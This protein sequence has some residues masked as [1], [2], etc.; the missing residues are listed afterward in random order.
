[1]TLTSIARRTLRLVALAGLLG[2]AHTAAAQTPCGATVCTASQFCVREHCYARLATSTP[3]TAGPS[4]ALSPPEAPGGSAIHVTVRQA[5]TAPGTWV[6]LTSAQEGPSA[7]LARRDSAGPDAT[8]TFTA[9]RAAGLY[10]IVLV[11]GDS[12]EIAA[13][14]DLVVGPLLRPREASAPVGGPMHV[15]VTH[16]T[17]H[18]S[19][20]VGL[21][22]STAPDT[23]FVTMQ[24][25]NGASSPPPTGLPDATLTF[26][27]PNKSADYNFRFFSADTSLPATTS[28]NVRV[29]TQIVPSRTTVAPDEPVTAAVFQPPTTPDDFAALFG[30]TAPDTL[31]TQLQPLATAPRA[32]GDPNSPAIIQI[33]APSVQAEVNLRAFSGASP[34]KVATSS[35]V[36]VTHASSPTDSPYGVVGS[37]SLGNETCQQTR[38]DDLGVRWVRIS[39]GWHE[40]EPQYRAYD[41]ALVERLFAYLYSR[42][43][44]V[45]WDFSY[46]P[47][48]A[49]GRPCPTDGDDRKFPPTPDHL[50]DMRQY[51]QGVVSR[52]AFYQGRRAPV[53]WGTWNEID[54]NFYRLPDQAKNGTQQVQ[55][56]SQQ[57]LPTVLSAIRA[58]DPGATIAVGEMERV[59]DTHTRDH[60]LLRT[61]LQAADSHGGFSLV[62]HHVYGWDN[63]VSGRLDGVRLLLTLLSD[64][65]YGNKDLWVT[66]VGIGNKARPGQDHFLV[67]F[68]DGMQA[69]W[70]R[71]WTKTFW[72]NFLPTGDVHDDAGLLGGVVPC[73]LWETSTYWTYHDYILGGAHA[74]TPLAP[75]GTI[76]TARPEYV[77]QVANRAD[78]YNLEVWGANGVIDTQYHAMAVCSGAVCEATPAI[79]LPNGAY[80]WAVQG[81]WAAGTAGPW[82]APLDFEVNVVG[83]C[84]DDCTY[85]TANGL[86]GNHT[87]DTVE[88]AIRL[89]EPFDPQHDV[90]TTCSA[91]CGVRGDHVCTPG[92][93]EN[94]LTSPT[95]CLCAAPLHCEQVPGAR[96]GTGA[97]VLQQSATNCGGQVCAVGQTCVDAQCL[98]IPPGCGDAI[99]TSD[100]DCGTC[101]DDCGCAPG[102]QCVGRQCG[103]ACGD[104]ICAPDVEGCGNCLQDCPCQEGEACVVDHCEANLCGDGVCAPDIEGCGNCLQD[105]PCP[106][107]EACVVDHCEANLCGDGICAPDVE[108]CGNCL[109]D[110]P[111]QEGEACVVDHCE[112]NLCGDGVCAPDI[113]G[114]GNCLQDCPCQEGEACV[115]DHC[116]ATLCGDGVCA[117]DIEGCGNCLQD[118]PCPEGEACAV[119]HCEAL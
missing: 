5:P 94:C 38:L 102:S 89:S 61:L 2:D 65:G 45:Y 63:T 72:Y 113:E 101:P 20:R 110:C 86:C 3:V 118:C 18:S 66:E 68:L 23:R 40:I 14:A 21:F 59:P 29:G 58:A 6:G 85:Y 87:C 80:R 74:P 67:G 114:C 46:A 100:E 7:P 48:W 76:D 44:G 82:S 26:V 93:F 17:G 107:G 60:P 109:Q 52:G 11:S 105:C 47:C 119:D 36:S 13:S 98:P 10:R 31:Y 55:H 92:A 50:E 62:S 41:W 104:G 53:V 90:S 73:D 95:D 71:R 78:R 30:S 111:C 112:A 115:V 34:V 43:Y 70:A 22:E 96:A 42:G 27:A 75:S 9:P 32:P 49:N 91:D 79:S 33:S 57:I 84:G 116:E 64:W 1:M 12:G 25:L 81:I 51:I 19:D 83:D 88:L 103:G 24:Y 97:C 106:E 15:T 37:P 35:S 69:G 39:F 16:G 8:Y 117:P 28:R 54:G 4:L 77:W 56:Y 99:C 108:G